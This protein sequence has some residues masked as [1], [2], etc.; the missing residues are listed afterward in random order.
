MFRFTL[1]LLFILIFSSIA[2]AQITPEQVDELM[3]N[4]RDSMRETEQLLARASTPPISAEDLFNDLLDFAEGE[5][6]TP[7]LREFL[8]SNPRLLA[9]LSNPDANE[10]QLEETEDEIRRLLYA[11]DRGL[12]QF[13]EANPEVIERFFDDEENLEAL[14]EEFLHAE[15]DLEGLFHETEGSMAQTEE[16]LIRLIEL[17]EEA[18]NMQPSPSQSQGQNDENL[19]QQDNQGTDPQTGSDQPTDEQQAQNSGQVGSGNQG[20]EDPNAW[21]ADLPEQMQQAARDATQGDR[22]QGYEAELEEF[23]RLLA[24]QARLQRERRE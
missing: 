19:Q 1:P 21:I 4:I 22:P 11:E 14:L 2:Q 17:V 16:E 20:I 6:I 13:F 9:E 12:E 18:S 8:E 3:R 5:E 23:Y 15:L 7:L 24:Q 10:E